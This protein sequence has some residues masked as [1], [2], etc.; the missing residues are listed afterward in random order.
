M[1][2][3]IHRNV[4]STCFI[5]LTILITLF[6]TWEEAKPKE[7]PISI[8]NCT[9]N[10]WQ[11][12]GLTPRWFGTK[13]HYLSPFPP[14][15]LFSSFWTGGGGWGWGRHEERRESERSTQETAFFQMKHEGGEFVQSLRRDQ[16]SQSIFIHWLPPPSSLP[17]FLFS[18]SL[19]TY[20]QQV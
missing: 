15:L 6:H 2:I 18:I 12:L 4:L 11:K 8:Y 10:Q 5:S 1:L 16:L 19:A 20:Y 14:G 13:C 7:I 9:A 3:S 17:L